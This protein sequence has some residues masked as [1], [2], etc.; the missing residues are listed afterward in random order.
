MFLISLQAVRNHKAL[1]YHHKIRIYIIVMLMWLRTTMWHEL[2]ETA[3]KFKSKRA[4]GTH[5]RW[6]QKKIKVANVQPTC[7]NC[8]EHLV[9]VHCPQI[10]DVCG[11][12]LGDYE[13]LI[14]HKKRL[15]KCNECRCPHCGK[16]F[17]Y[18]QH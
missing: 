11:K 14:Y 4:I 18:A 1:I 5:K 15:K 3:W 7:S 16:T 17:K 10:C 2:N 13:T 6:W 9:C 12:I 8:N